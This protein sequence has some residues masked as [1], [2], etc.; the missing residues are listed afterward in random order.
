MAESPAPPPNAP[1]SLGPLH[2]H[3]VLNLV[4]QAVGVYAIVFHPSW[5]GLGLA[6]ALHFLVSGLGITVGYHRLLSHRAFKTVKPVEWLLAALGCLAMHG[7]PIQWVTI[8]RQHHRYA[9]T[10]LDPHSPIHGFL[11]SHLLWFNAGFFARTTP[12]H[13]ATYAKDLT[14]QAFYRLLRFAVLPLM[15]GAL[16]GL[17][18]WGGAEAVL[19]G[20]FVR[21]LLG[22]HA[23]WFVNSAGHTL[24]WRAY[25]RDDRS[26]NCS[27][28]GL[29][30]FGEGF[31]NNHHAFPSSARLGL[32]PWELDMGWWVILA[33][34]ALGLAW[35]VN[36]PSREEIECGHLPADL[37]ELAGLCR[38][39]R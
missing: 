17:W 36:R 24:G 23:T 35:D 15:L 7:D 30:A 34:E 8:H 25:K 33:L 20:G 39:S 22:D 3:F 5:T 13:E 1:G 9:D 29:V 38:P 16:Y 10:D 31:H 2:P 32:R 6:L 21:Y 4:G 12:H 11:W 28:V 14:S 27:W 19:W 26:T 37:L 18:A